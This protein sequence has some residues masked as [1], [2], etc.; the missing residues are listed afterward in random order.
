MQA[1]PPSSIC[2]RGPYLRNSCQALF[3]NLSPLRH[4]ETFLVA[5]FF[6]GINR[7]FRYKNRK[8]RTR[9]IILFLFRFSLLLVI[10]IN[11]SKMAREQ[12][13]GVKSIKIFFFYLLDCLMLLGK[14]GICDGKCLPRKIYHVIFILEFFVN[15]SPCTYE[16]EG[17]LYIATS[18]L[19]LDIF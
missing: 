8:G 3:L 14:M 15:I 19:V 6:L 16:I 2:V 12:S 11:I 17:P 10:C 18:K 5:V 7:M 4:Q 1:S 9:Y 13:S